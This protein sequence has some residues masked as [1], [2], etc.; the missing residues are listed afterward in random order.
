L[1]IGFIGPSYAFSWFPKRRDSLSPTLPPGCNCLTRTSGSA[2]SACLQALHGPNREHCLQMSG[3]SQLLHTLL[4]L[5]LRSILTDPN[6]R[7]GISS[8][9]V[10]LCLT[11]C[12]RLSQKSTVL[13]C[14]SRAIISF[15]PCPSFLIKCRPIGG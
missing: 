15:R 2:W 9:S 6:I 8:L 12:P 1:V 5:I 7:F 10:C 11:V 4:T 14:L 3:A 13:L